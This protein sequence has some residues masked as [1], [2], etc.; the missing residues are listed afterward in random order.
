MKVV[1]SFYCRI[2]KKSYK[3]GDTYTGDRKDLYPLY[4]EKPKRKP[5]KENKKG[6]KAKL[7]KK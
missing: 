4:V 3:V 7:E 2:E 5:K 1:N 6:P